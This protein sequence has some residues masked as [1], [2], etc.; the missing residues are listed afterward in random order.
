MIALSASPAHAQAGLAVPEG[1]HLTLFALGV[2]GVI[3]G[4]GIASKRR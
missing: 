3:I 4:R 1:S 2:L